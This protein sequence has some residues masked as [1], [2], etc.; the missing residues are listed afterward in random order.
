MPAPVASR[1][2]RGY[3]LA[4][5]L[6]VITVIGV[7][8]AIAIA[9]IGAVGDTGDRSACR[10]NLRQ[11]TSAQEAHYA[12]RNAYADVDALV[13]AGYLRSAPPTNHYVIAA[14]AVTGEVTVDPPGCREG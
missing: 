5:V 6:I 2:Q 10:T 12:E 13:A 11:V 4:E 7:L 14:D 3:T 8:A 9:A 1:H